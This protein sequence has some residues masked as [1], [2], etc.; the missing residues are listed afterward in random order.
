MRTLVALLCVAGVAFA[1]DQQRQDR[2]TEFLLNRLKEQLKL[3]EDQTGKVKEILTRDAEDRQKADDAR[4]AKISEVLNEEQ[5]KQYE[6]MRRQFRA[7][8][9]GGGRAFGGGQN[10]FGQLQVEDLKRDLELSDEQVDKIRPIYD[11]FNARAQKRMEELRQ[12]GFQGLNWQEE[13][14]KFRDAITEAGDKIKPHLTDAQKGKYDQL[15]EQRMQFLR[16]IPGQGGGAG[17]PAGGPARPSVEDR[18]KRAMEALKIDKEEE[19]RAVA[20]LVAKIIRAQDALEDYARSSRDRL[21]EAGKNRELSNEALEDR[22]KEVR[23]ERR[24]REKELAALQ[25]DLAE[26]VSQR[27]EIELVAQGILK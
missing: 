11:E 15:V 6:E 1:Q 5:K 26:I 18:V 8:G 16:F 10:R 19:A 3:T 21:V 22:L 20:D 7:G 25:K 17:R 14:Q 12:G 2:G 27:Q 13:M 9:G 4:A 24:K 23:E